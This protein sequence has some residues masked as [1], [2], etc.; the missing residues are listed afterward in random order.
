MS[1]N[2]RMNWEV[3]RRRRL[4]LHSLRGTYAVVALTHPEGFD[5]DARFM[6]TVE[7]H[8]LR[9]SDDTGL[10]TV[11]IANTDDQ[12][13]E[14]DHWSAD[15]DINEQNEMVSFPFWSLERFFEHDGQRSVETVTQPGDGTLVLTAWFGPDRITPRQFQLTKTND[16]PG[17]DGVRASQAWS[18]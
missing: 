7:L 9:F 14:V 3:I 13:V 18:Y 17:R 12:E 15:L 2:R 1:Y 8:A 16:V 6:A 4:P 10:H 11:H 5:P